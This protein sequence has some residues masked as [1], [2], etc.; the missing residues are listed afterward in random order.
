MSRPSFLHNTGGA[1][2]TTVN[3]A[4]MRMVS[5][6]NKTIEGAVKDKPG[7]ARHRIIDAFARV[8]PSPVRLLCLKQC[9]SFT[10]SA[11]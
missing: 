1:T 6:E 5:I 2:S 7:A 9:K 11:H 10:N 8:K 3:D 4:P